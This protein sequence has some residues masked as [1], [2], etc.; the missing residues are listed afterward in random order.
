MSEGGRRGETSVWHGQG[1]K[2][3]CREPVGVDSEEWNYVR[4]RE[5]GS[6]RLDR[7]GSDLVSG[8][9]FFVFRRHTV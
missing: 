4:A 1:D 6:D 9:E 7:G 3:K 5:G 2:E 8:F